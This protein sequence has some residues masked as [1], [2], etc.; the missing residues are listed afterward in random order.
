LAFPV[1][2]Y[3][4]VLGQVLARIF[5]EAVAIKLLEVELLDQFVLDGTTRENAYKDVTRALEAK[6][7]AGYVSETSSSAR[8]RQR[9]C[10]NGEPAGL[11]A[12]R[13]HEAGRGF[14]AHWDQKCQKQA[15]EETVQRSVGK[16]PPMLPE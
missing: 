7:L 3:G 8:A 11:A 2:G 12:I 6:H 1:N 5:H 16:Q 14:E 9:G 13:G 4:G 15:G 10:R